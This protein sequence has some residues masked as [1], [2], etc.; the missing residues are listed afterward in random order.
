MHDGVAP[1]E[2]AKWNRWFAIETNNRAW[3]LSESTLRT[4]A[5]D[6]EMLHSAHAAALHWSKVGTELHNARAAMLLGHVHALLGLGATALPYARRA[7]DYVQSHDSPPWEVAFAHAVLANAAAAAG[8]RD[9]HAR[10]Y[11]AAR[12]LGAQIDNP[13]ERAIFDAT[14]RTV[15]RSC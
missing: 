8:N 14:F 15:R 2:L 6:A 4:E 3:R 7:Y 5:E 11:A 1:E 13:E 9:L 10:H 12:D